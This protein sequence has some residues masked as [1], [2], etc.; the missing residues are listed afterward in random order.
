MLI[1]SRSVLVSG[2]RSGLPVAIHPVAEL[3]K[4][5]VYQGFRERTNGVNG[6]MICW[7]AGTGKP[8]SLFQYGLLIVPQKRK[9]GD[10][11]SRRWLDRSHAGPYG[12]RVHHG[13]RKKRPPKRNP[14]STSNDSVGFPR[15]QRNGAAHII[16]YVGKD[17]FL[18]ATDYPHDDHPRYMAAL[19]TLVAR[20]SEPARRGISATSYGS[21]IRVAV[22]VMITLGKVMAGTG[23]FTLDSGK[24]I[25]GGTVVTQIFSATATSPAMIFFGLVAT[26]AAV[27]I[28]LAIT[29][30]E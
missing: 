9:S 26:V 3:P 20:L 1:R 19:D 6:G 13:A 17:K 2:A 16:D 28:G 25:F 30:E 7:R 24:L 10:V 18:W 12:R 11:G 27:V 21:I 5:R 14:V 29:P 22:Q 4:R 8:F 15:T 23:K